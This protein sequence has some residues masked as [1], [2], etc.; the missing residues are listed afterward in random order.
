MAKKPVKRMP[1]KPAP[2]PAR[3]G[4]AGKRGPVP[5]FAA[6]ATGANTK[7]KKGGVAPKIAGKGVNKKGSKKPRTGKSGY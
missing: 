1:K 4:K 6:K 7:T 5:P 2:A 3:K